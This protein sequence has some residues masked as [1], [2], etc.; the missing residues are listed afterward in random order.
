MTLTQF[1]IAKVRASVTHIVNIAQGIKGVDLSVRLATE[2]PEATG[3]EILSCI[4]DMISEGEL[5]EVEYELPLMT[6]RTK[7]F[8][9]PRG[10]SININKIKPHNE[11]TK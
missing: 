6:Y 7:S 8:I 2:H 3:D 11:G 9:L 5:V 1:G 4:F 10:T